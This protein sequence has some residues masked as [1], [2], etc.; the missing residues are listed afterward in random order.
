MMT[1]E[2]LLLVFTA[3]ATDSGDFVGCFF[4]AFFTFGVAAAVSRATWWY[5]TCIYMQ[6]IILASDD[7]Y[8]CMHNCMYICF[9]DL[10]L[11]GLHLTTARQALCCWGSIGVAT[12]AARSAARCDWPEAGDIPTNT[13]DSSS[14]SVSSDR[15]GNGAQPSLL[16]EYTQQFSWKKQSKSICI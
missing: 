12:A 14:L 10:S 8:A 7:C 11:Q 6:W 5:W 1:G 13:T 16:I 15:S 3:L 2:L 9:N 4:V